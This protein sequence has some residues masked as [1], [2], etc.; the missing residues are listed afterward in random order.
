ME[1]QV[2]KDM[3]SYLQTN[4]ID[5]VDLLDQGKDFQCVEFYLY[6]A[7]CSKNNIKVKWQDKDGSYNEKEFN[8]LSSVVVQHEVDHLNGIIF[9]DYDNRKK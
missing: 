2:V 3:L 1:T 7:W 8:N 9:L 4:N 6:S 5:L